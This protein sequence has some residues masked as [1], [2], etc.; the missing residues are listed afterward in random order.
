MNTAVFISGNGSN[1][2]AI[3]DFWLTGESKYELKLVLSNSAN[4]FG[5]KRAAEVGL[6]TLVIDHNDFE[7]RLDFDRQIDAEIKKEK[8]ELIALAGFMRLLSPWFVQQWSGRLLNIHPSLLPAFPGLHTHKKALAYGVKYSG[9]TVFFVD[10]GIDTGT[11]IDQASVKVMDE[12][13]ENLLAVRVLKKEHLIFPKALD[14]VARK[15]VCLVNGQIKKLNGD[16][17]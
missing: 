6:K 9:C 10:E 16:K 3:I 7:T 2:Q 5:L 4:A 8:I 17:L 11:I 15:E 13:T 12:D 1:L 14:Q